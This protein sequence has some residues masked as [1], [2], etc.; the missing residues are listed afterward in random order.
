MVIDGTPNNLEPLVFQ[1]LLLLIKNQGQVVSKQKVIDTLWADKK[2]TDEALRA[3]VKKT[4]EALKDNARNPTFVKTI[5]TKG[6]LLIPPVELKSTETKPWKNISKNYYTAIGLVVTLLVFIAAWQYERVTEPQ[7][8]LIESNIIVSKTDYKISNKVSAYYINGAL[9]LI[10]LDEASSESHT[11]IF[12]KNIEQNTSLNIALEGQLDTRIYWSEQ[13]QRMLVMRN[14]RKGHYLIQF[15]RGKDEPTIRFNDTNLTPN[16][17]I[18]AF[19][20]AGNHLIVASTNEQDSRRWLIEKWD[21]N[22]AQRTQTPMLL[23]IQQHINMQQNQALDNTLESIFNVRVWPSTSSEDV[24]ITINLNQQTKFYHYSSHQNEQAAHIFAVPKIS[25]ETIDD[26]VWGRNAERFSFTDQHNTLYSFLVDARRLTTWRTKGQKFNMV[27]EDCGASCF[28]VANTLSP[29]KISGNIQLFDSNNA[30]DSAQISLVRID[31]RIETLPKYVGDKLY[32]VAK[33]KQGV[34]IVRRERTNQETN[35]YTFQG[36]VDIDELVIDAQQNT[37]AGVLNMRPFIIDLSTNSLSFLPISFPYVS[38]LNFVSESVLRFYARSAQGLY[39]SDT[40]EQV[41]GLYE[42]RLDTKQTLLI[43]ENTKVMYPIQ[44]TQ[45]LDGL[46]S[47]QEY[48]FEIDVNNYAFV[49][50][51]NSQN[52]QEIINLGQIQT[53]CIGCWYV[54]G[55][56]LYMLSNIRFGASGEV[57]TYMVRTHL[58]D[59]QIETVPVAIGEISKEFTF[60]TTDQSFTFV[61][62]QKRHSNLV[63]MEGA[64]L[65]Y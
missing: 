35:I 56:W 45:E 33:D 41:N 8:E 18:L 51:K 50:S 64:A 54:N 12:I 25:N 30:A 65:I 15:E 19:D 52:E 14:D 59:A 27:V 38:H 40:S 10:G 46:V 17:S 26:G 20:Q 2:P 5:P 53:S 61:T 22:T 23:D 58:L 11:Q 21:I 62:R 29:S 57:A 7:D 13:V 24:M 4:R 43:K 49:S 1:F 37:A 32:F 44:L 60:D 48:V 55:N 3:M 16:F 31:S 34:R 6:Y 63:K 28:F 42:Y 9:N 36:Q 47:K 39:N